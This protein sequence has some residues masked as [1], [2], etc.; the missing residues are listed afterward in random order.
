MERHGAAQASVADGALHLVAA[1][2][3]TAVLHPLV[4]FVTDPLAGDAD[5]LVPALVAHV[6]APRPV[7]LLLVRRGGYAVGVVDAGRLT[8]SKVGTRY[9]QSRT[10]AGGWSQQR[11]ARRRDN[12]AAALL[13]TLAATAVRL[14]LGADGRSAPPG[15]V[16]VT[17]GDRALA[18]ELMDD[19]RLAALASARAGRHLQVPDPRKDVLQRAVEQALAVQV[20]V[21]NA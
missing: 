16:V 19:P 18:D 7:V 17:G 12:Q 20:D 11:F 10:A 1:D 3:S 14:V 5:D 15:V 6:S 2:R 13:D 4:P 8:A 9:V 21:V